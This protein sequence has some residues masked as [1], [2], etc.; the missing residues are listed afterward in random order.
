MKKRILTLA[1]ALLLCVG[2]AAPALA[3][4]KEDYER[5]HFSHFQSDGYAIL[6]GDHPRGMGLR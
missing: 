1:M 2:L 3:D 4:W 5:N 6:P